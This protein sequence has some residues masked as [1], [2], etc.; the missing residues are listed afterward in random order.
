MALLLDPASIVI[1]EYLSL[2]MLISGAIPF[3]ESFLKENPPRYY[4]LL[5]F[6]SALAAL[7]ISCTNFDAFENGEVIVEDRT[8]FDKVEELL[9]KGFKL[10][11]SNYVD[12][13]NN[14]FYSCASHFQALLATR[15]ITYQFRS[16]RASI[17]AA[18][19]H[20]LTPI[21]VAESIETKIQ[22]E[23]AV[24]E[25]ALRLLLNPEGKSFMMS[26][27]TDQF[28]FPAVD[29]DEIDLDWF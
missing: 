10:P 5:R 25:Q 4:R 27:L 11:I 24:L 14:E 7:E 8:L 29:L 18:S 28:G 21:K 26:E 20:F 12:A 15:L 3:E 1:E 6:K 9:V 19:G 23:T 13:N 2:K 16:Q 22:N 17:L